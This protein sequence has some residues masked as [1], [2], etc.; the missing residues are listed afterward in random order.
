MEENS[1]AE[2]LFMWIIPL[3]LNVYVVVLSLD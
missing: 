1:K 2:K 3:W